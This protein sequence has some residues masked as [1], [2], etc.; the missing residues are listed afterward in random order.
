MNSLRSW[1]MPETLLIE[2]DRLNAEHLRRAAEAAHH[3][4]QLTIVHYKE[5]LIRMTVSIVQVL[6]DAIVQCWS[7]LEDDCEETTCQRLGENARKLFES[8]LSLLT[9]FEQE[10]EQL[11]AKGL[12][13]SIAHLLGPAS[14]RVREVSE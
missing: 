14:A 12:P 13:V 9:L 7:P 6:D 4:G 2:C 8:L 5:G 10:S 11:A 3:E 1:R